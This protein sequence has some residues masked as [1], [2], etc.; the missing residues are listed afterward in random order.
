[1]CVALFLSGRPGQTY[2]ASSRIEHSI[3]HV[4]V[5]DVGKAALL[6]GLLVVLVPP[7]QPL[8]AKVKG[9]PEGLVDAVEDVAPRHKHPLKG[10]RAGPRVGGH[11]DWLVGSPHGVV[12]WYSAV[13]RYG[14]CAEQ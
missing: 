14:N 7:A 5:G 4:F 3:H 12:K 2:L 10:R 11:K 6:P 13:E 1:M 8:R 9:V